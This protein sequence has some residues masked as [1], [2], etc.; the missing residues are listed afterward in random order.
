MSQAPDTDITPLVPPTCQK[1]ITQALRHIDRLFVDDRSHRIPAY[2]ADQS[3]FLR[4]WNQAQ[5][6]GLLAHQAAL[7]GDELATRRAC[8]LWYRVL[9]DAL[10]QAQQ[11]AEKQ[12]VE[13]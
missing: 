2:A 5:A 11:A 8:R 9:K 13:G 6:H 1:Y 7:T 10:R 12:V 3:L 4:C